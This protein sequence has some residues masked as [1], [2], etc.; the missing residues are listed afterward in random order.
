MRP[1]STDPIPLLLRLRLLTALS[2]GFPEGKQN[3][4]RVVKKKELEKKE[5]KAL[6]FKKFD[7]FKFSFW[8]LT[9]GGS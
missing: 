3:L 5:K 7:H 1:S 2:P 9:L 4:G 8:H 6:Q